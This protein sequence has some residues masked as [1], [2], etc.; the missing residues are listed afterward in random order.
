MKVS[1]NRKK[2][3]MMKSVIIS[4]QD[5]HFIKKP[6]NPTKYFDEMR[7]S[8]FFGSYFFVIFN[9]LIDY[10]IIFSSVT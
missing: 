4:I 10:L 9:L 6:V 7:L 2:L 5:M 3:F 8:D 1:G